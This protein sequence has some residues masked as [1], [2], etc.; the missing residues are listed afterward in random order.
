VSRAPVLSVEALMQVM[1]E[2]TTMR[3]LKHFAGHRLPSPERWLRDRRRRSIVLD[4]R[5]GY[6][7]GDLAAKY[8]MSPHAIKKIITEA[9]RARRQQMIDKGEDPWIK[10]LSD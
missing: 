7:I 8:N 6:A 4:Y 5:R 9:L 10:T 2:K 3:L 1:G